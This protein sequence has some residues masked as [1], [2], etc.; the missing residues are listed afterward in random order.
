MSEDEFESLY[1]TTY[2]NIFR[3]VS[4]NAFDKNLVEDIVQETYKQAYIKKDLLAQH[5]NILGWL[6]LTAKCIMLSMHKKESKHFTKRVDNEENLLE[7]VKDSKDEFGFLELETTIEKEL[8]EKNKE[9]LFQY[10]V[11]GLSSEEIMEEYQISSSCL[12]MRMKRI[13]D[14]LKKRI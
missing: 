12:K 7:K 11:E 2:I 14:Q 13:R 9:M 3:Y 6:V 4:R 8:D 10:Y 1:Q 5:E